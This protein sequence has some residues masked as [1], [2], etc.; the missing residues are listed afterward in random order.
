MYEGKFLR[1]RMINKGM[2]FDHQVKILKPQ[3]IMKNPIRTFE[4]VQ[5]VVLLGQGHRI[6]HL[7][8]ERD[9][10]CKEFNISNN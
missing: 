8:L 5:D 6:G 4:F 1:R 3:E 2:Y 7:Q 10:T 9:C